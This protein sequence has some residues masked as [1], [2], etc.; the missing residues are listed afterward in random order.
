MKRIFFLVLACVAG[1]PA[2]S[3]AAQGPQGPPPLVQ[4]APVALVDANQPEKYI[5]HVESM[6]S[7]DLRAR[8][9]GYLEKLNFKEGS[10][11]QKGQIL[12]VIEQAPYKARVA[13]ARA[14]VA[15][16]EADLFK[17]KTR[18]ER[19]RSAHPESV[20]KTD[21]DDA[22]AARD[23][24]R[25]RLDEAR[26]N[27]ELAE[28][29]L[30]YTTVEAPITGRIG[31]SR[32]KVGDLVGPSSQPMAEIVR[33]D[34]IRVVFSVSENQGKIIMNA[35]KD[36]EKG[37]AAS[38]LSV[39]LEFSGGQAYPR[40]G[41]IDFVDN[42]VDPDT[43]TIAIWARFENPDGRLVP[44]EYVRVFL[45]EA[46]QEMI[47]AVAQAAVQRDKEGAFVYVLDEKNKV[48]KRRITTGH[49]RDGKFIVTSG[50][51]PGEKV[52]VQ[53]IQKVK[54]GISVH[55]KGE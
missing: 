41:E 47:P 31:K 3:W 26:A 52:I 9:E 6:E 1:I 38:I 25:G 48:E 53:G 18:L 8:V 39:S 45:E 29:D 42:R 10:F 24:A 50:L 34:P 43:G 7:I 35:L 51:K 5:G 46:K 33:M 36:S 22:V 20:P 44:G 49:A 4:A 15:Q 27:L 19:L 28:I 55:I 32:Y 21:L 30:D 16:A 12:Y 37:D 14:K 40:K 13:A 17:A 11:V 54:P 23:L 2:L